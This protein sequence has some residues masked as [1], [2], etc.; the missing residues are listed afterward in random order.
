MTETLLELQRFGGILDDYG[1]GLDNIKQTKQYRKLDKKVKELMG[2]VYSAE[3]SSKVN[4]FYNWSE[5]LYCALLS[6]KPFSD[7]PEIK[8]YVP[9]RD[10]QT[11]KLFKPLAER[12]LATLISSVRESIIKSKKK[13]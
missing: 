10:R 9:I 11:A 4:D 7:T 13:D 5:G 8:E 2:R 12:F 1:L 3:T 6:L